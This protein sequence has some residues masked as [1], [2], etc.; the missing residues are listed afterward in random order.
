MQKKRKRVQL[1]T[2]EKRRFVDKIKVNNH[3]VDDLQSLVEEWNA[4]PAHCDRQINLG[5]LQRLEIPKFTAEEEFVASI[6]ARLAVE[7]AKPGA[8]EMYEPRAKGVDYQ[9]RKTERINPDKVPFL[10]G[11]ALKSLRFPFDSAKYNRCE[12]DEQREASSKRLHRDFREHWS[13][14]GLVVGRFDGFIYPDDRANLD[15][16]YGGTDCWS[17]SDEKGPWKAVGDAIL[18]NKKILNA[19]KQTF[20]F[21][22][23]GEKE[24]RINPKHAMLKPLFA[25]FASES[26]QAALSAVLDISEA[27]Y[28]GVS[29]LLP[30]DQRKNSK[31]RR[32]AINHEMDP[33]N[34]SLLSCLS[35]Q[36][37]VQREHMDDHA[38]GVAGLWGLVDEEQYLIFWL[39]SYEMNLELEKIY[40]FRDFVLRVSLSFAGF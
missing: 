9:D 30:T 37:K 38:R 12:T 21:S 24:D 16:K 20:V 8:K 11:E 32:Y 17:P 33:A 7:L 3:S 1:S 23:Q 28:R 15:S 29:G 39:H 34:L 18:K 13:A 6:A 4:D 31:W 36:T 27:V 14:R 26:D 2:D 10:D 19:A 40:E 35:L 5:H 22:E 25:K